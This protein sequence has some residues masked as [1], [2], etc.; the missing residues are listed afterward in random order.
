MLDGVEFGKEVVDLVRGYVERELAPLKTE[1]EG[2]KARVA[3]L[4]AAPA[5]EKGDPGENGADGVSPAPEAIAEAFVPLAEQI[6]TGAVVKAVAELSV[7]VGE[8]GEPGERGE[9]GTD[10]K[11]GAD[12]RGVKELL[13][14]RDGN[15]VASMDDGEMKSLGPVIG[16]DGLDGND[17][18][19][20]NDGR[21]GF[22]IDDFDCRVLEDDRTIELAFRAGENEHIATLKW[23]TVIDRGVWKEQSYDQGDGVT[24]GGSYWIAQSPNP[25]GKPDT[26]DSGWRLACKRG[27]DGKDAKGG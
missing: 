25:P 2:L 26:K 1:N 5:P 3:A 21:D 19:P 27:R 18:A 15:L 20:G 22:S 13:I 6:I 9:A 8:K 4:E 11:D 23:P 14:D 7:P 12:G 24:W 10:G 17:G 16:K